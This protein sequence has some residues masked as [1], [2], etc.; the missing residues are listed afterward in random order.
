MLLHPKLR[1]QY[2]R[3]DIKS[4]SLWLI[5][6]PVHAPIFMAMTISG[7]AAMTSLGALVCLAW[8]VHSLA[9]SPLLFPTLPFCCYLAATVATYWLRLTAFTV[10]HDAAF[11][12]EAKLRTSLAQKLMRLSLSDTRA[13]GAGT[14]ANVMQEDVRSLHA[15]VAD[16]TPLYARAIVMPAATFLVAAYC[17]WALAGGMLAVLLLGGGVM[18]WARCH[19][20]MGHQYGQARERVSAAIIEFMQA[21]PVVRMFDG[22]SSS[23]VSYQRAL[24]AWRDVLTRWYREASCSARLS[25]ALIGPLPTLL[26]LVWLGY[27]L[28]AQGTLRP[29]AWVT[30]LLIGSGMA[31]AVMPMISLQQLVKHTRLCAL[32]IQRLLAQ[33]EQP[34]PKQPRFP[35]DA[36]V[37]FH[38]VSY[39]YPGGSGDTTLTD[40][41]FHAAAGSMT[42]L[43]GASGAGK[44]TAMRL[45]CRFADATEGEIALGGV[46]VRAMT[47]DTLM[48]QIAYVAQDT[49]LFA[50]TVAANISVGMSG[51]SRDD[52]VAAARLACADDFIERLPN[53]YDTVVSEKGSSLSGGQRQRLAVARALLQQRPLM[54]LDEAT[55][56]LDSTNEAALMA[57]LRAGRQCRTIFFITHKPAIAALADHVV[58]FAR[59]RI[60]A[61]GTHAALWATVPDYAAL[62]AT[63]GDACGAQS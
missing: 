31:E 62:W 25:F 19:G 61:Q 38:H 29:F 42:A 6:A 4:G 41:D 23:F 20:N 5:M 51:A 8:I 3:N 44:S 34:Q 9:L 13:L 50:D 11:L 22:G 53:G 45:L 18:Y 26:V 27:G 33:P 59:G 39:R 60:V 49:F 10:S 15:F 57:S 7:A 35:A 43:V 63:A 47:T 55:A 46:N 52:I 21:M 17:D 1:A 32:R 56:F 2:K 36:S 37:T 24:K 30:V 48:Q 40:I 12:L 28:A 16:S 58:F 54:V 14:L